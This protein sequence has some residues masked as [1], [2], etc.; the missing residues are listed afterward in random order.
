MKINLPRNL[1]FLRR[2]SHFT[3]KDVA[4]WL[5]VDRSSY[6]YYETGHSF[7]QLITLL[8]LTWFFEVSLDDLVLTDLVETPPD[9]VWALLR[10]GI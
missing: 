6:T 9:Y 8:K 4:L 10:Q 5:R 3:Q 2:C 7:P 1:R